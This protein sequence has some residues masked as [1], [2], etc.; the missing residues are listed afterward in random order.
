VEINVVSQV[1]EEKETQKK[2]LEMGIHRP[3]DRLACYGTIAHQ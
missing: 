3:K 2:Y 1:D